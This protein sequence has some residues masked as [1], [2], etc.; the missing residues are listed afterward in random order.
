MKA[1]VSVDDSEGVDYDAES[2]VY[3]TSYDWN[4]PASLSE[5]ILA[6]VSTVTGCDPIE[7]PPLYEQVDPACLEELFAPEPG[8][9]RRSGSITFRLGD[10]HVTIAADGELVVYPPAEF[11]E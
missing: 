10:C 1:V 7:L 2:G 5:A 8:C 6:A 11:D 3:R 4:S 9:P